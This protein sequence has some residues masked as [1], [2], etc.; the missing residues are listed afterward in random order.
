MW[1][2]QSYHEI[3]SQLPY[4]DYERIQWPK[5]G[6]YKNIVAPTKKDMKLEVRA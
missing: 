4:T 6:Y 2:V 5:R 3:L 1:F